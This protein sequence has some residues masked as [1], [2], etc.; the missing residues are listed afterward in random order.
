M[1]IK[2][3]MLIIKELQEYFGSGRSVLSW[4]K[5]YPN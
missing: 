3:Y 1:E 4:G 5:I 2:V